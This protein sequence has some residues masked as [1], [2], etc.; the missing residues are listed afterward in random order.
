MSEVY[1]YE[2][3]LRP[4]V[5]KFLPQTAKK[6]TVLE[7]GCGYGHFRKNIRTEC[8]YWG[9]EPVPSIA[10]FA[11]SNLEKILVG[12]FDE[13]V[14]TLP[15][16]FFDCIVCN[17]VIEHMN[18]VDDFLQIIKTKMK[19]EGVIVGSIP[20]VRYIDNLF[21]LL[22]LKDWKY[23]DSGILDKTHLRFFTQKSL[24]RTFKLNGYVIEELSGINPINIKTDSIKRFFLSLGA[25]VFS[26]LIGVD[27]KFTQFGF[28]I[29]LK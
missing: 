18:N 22:I 14:D 27:S 8:E 25:T 21:R 24:I 9:I 1:P 13:I 17:D 26:Y 11:S 12:T 4:E 19:K 6:M 23:E 7:V 3:H 29:R 5:A 2:H 20:N 16:N 28:R 10:Q 15:D